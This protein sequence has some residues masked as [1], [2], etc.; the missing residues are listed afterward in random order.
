MC[1]KPAPSDGR[2]REEQ[3]VIGIILKKSIA[4]LTKYGKYAI[5]VY[6]I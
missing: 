5:M 2:D 6:I 1:R 3:A 4:F